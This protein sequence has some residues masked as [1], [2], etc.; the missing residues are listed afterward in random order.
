MSIESVMGISLMARLSWFVRNF[1]NLAMILTVTS[2]TAAE[3]HVAKNGDDATGN[4]SSGNPYLT[5]QRALDGL[6]GGGDQ[7]IVHAGTYTE[8]HDTGTDRFKGILFK[9]GGDSAVNQLIVRVADGDHVI[10]DQQ[11]GPI[12]DALGEPDVVDKIAGFI[13]GNN[14]HIV[15]EGFEIK[16]AIVG[17]YAVNLRFLGVLVDTDVPNNIVIRGNHIHHITGGTGNSEPGHPTILV[18]DNVGAIRLDKCW[19]CEVSDNVLH[20]IA[21]VKTRPSGLVNDCP[22]DIGTGAP[23]TFCKQLHCRNADE[24]TCFGGTGTG[25]QAGIHSFG[26]ENPSIHNNTIFNV[27]T[28]VYHKAAG[29]GVGDGGEI[30]RNEI[31]DTEFGIRHS[32]AGNCNPPHTAV[33]V[34]ENLFF[35]VKTPPM[36]IGYFSDAFNTHTGSGL[37]VVYN[38]TFTSRHGVQV[39]SFADT[40]IFN[41]IF[42]SEGAAGRAIFR[43]DAAR[44]KPVECTGRGVAQNPPFRAAITLSD[45]NAFLRDKSDS[46]ALGTTGNFFSPLSAWQAGA[47]GDCSLNAVN[48]TCG[49]NSIEAADIR[50]ASTPRKG[51]PVDGPYYTLQAG[52]PAKNVG[53]ANI[54]NSPA[55]ALVDMGAYPVP[56]ADQVGARIQVGHSH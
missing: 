17:V 27:H 32:V 55:G 18:P 41:N 42:H 34:Y 21:G 8:Q 3:I 43:S 44:A 22:I 36:N 39:D 26:M 16:N 49:L 23:K 33:E 30:F 15:I 45:H 1:V 24:P 9:S 11:N 52:S 7:V 48:G 50:F 2:L 5:I 29:A 31:F 4:G 35:H 51:A 53:R 19:D 37:L 14:D 40:R 6:P 20:D 47:T 54:A 13:I 28:G 46:I 10:I 25:N 12:I 38:N 56:G